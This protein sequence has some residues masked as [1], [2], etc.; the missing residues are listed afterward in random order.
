MA[1]YARDSVIELMPTSDGQQYGRKYVNGHPAN[2]GLDLQIVTAF[3][4]SANL[5]NGYPVW[6][7]EM[8]LLTA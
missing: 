5:S 6:M 1:A 3:V 4:V 2:M 7:S 8:T